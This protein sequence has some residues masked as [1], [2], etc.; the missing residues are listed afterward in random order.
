MPCS[1]WSFR[2]GIGRK[3]GFYESYAT[4]KDAEEPKGGKWP[5]VSVYHS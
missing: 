4:W 2:T 1:G 5:W 3:C